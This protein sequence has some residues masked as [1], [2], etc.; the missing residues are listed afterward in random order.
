MNGVN[1][2]PA[3]NRGGVDI[4]VVDEKRSTEGQDLNDDQGFNT[5]KFLPHSFLQGDFLM[6]QSTVSF[7]FLLLQGDIGL[8]IEFQ[9]LPALFVYQLCLLGI[10]F[11]FL[12]GRC[13]MFSLYL[14]QLFLVYVAVDHFV[15]KST[16]QKPDIVMIQP[17]SLTV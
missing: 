6:S 11:Q 2:K 13:P 16:C 4:D 3:G 17:S 15:L 14:I 10:H 8:V 5:L 7:F 9:C 12:R 1:T